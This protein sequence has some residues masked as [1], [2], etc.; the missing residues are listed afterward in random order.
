MKTKRAAKGANEIR[1]FGNALREVL[2]L[3]LLYCDLTPG[4]DDRREEKRSLHRFYSGEQPWSGGGDGM[5]AKH[6]AAP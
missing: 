6:G 5:N 2:G 1:I 3:D 4:E